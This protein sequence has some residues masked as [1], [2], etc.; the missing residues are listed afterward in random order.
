MAPLVK[1]LQQSNRLQVEFRVTPHHRQMLYQVVQLFEITPGYDLD[2][3]SLS[4]TLPQLTCNILQSMA[5]ILAQSQPVWVLVH[6]ETSTT[7]AISQ[8]AYY[9]QIG[10]AHV[11]AGLRTNNLYSRWPE[12]ANRQITRRLAGPHFALTEKARLNLLKEG[13]NP[14]TFH[15]TGNTVI[16]ALLKVSQRINTDAELC[17]TLAAQFPYLQPEK[18][19]ILVTGHRRQNFGAGFEAVCDALKGIA[20]EPGVQMGSRYTSTPKCKSRLTASW[21]A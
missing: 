12:E 14:A 18:R 17:T 7:M 10:I 20:S 4:Q 2:L 1:V 5:R 9:H 16:D 19:L 21:V 11:K 6:V 15:G 3:M 8:A 13:I